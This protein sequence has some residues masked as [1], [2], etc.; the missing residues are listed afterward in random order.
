LRAGAG[1]R[2]NGG[3]RGVTTMRAEIKTVADEIRQSLDLLRRYL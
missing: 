3:S 2:Y 1:G